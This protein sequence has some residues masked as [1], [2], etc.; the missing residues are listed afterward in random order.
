MKNIRFCFLIFIG[1][2]TIKVQAQ[3]A[4]N[5][6]DIFQ[7][8]LIKIAKTINKEQQSD[9]KKFAENGKFVKTL[10]DALKEP[11]SFNYAFDSLKT[12]S[13]IKSPDQVFRII[14][15]YL[16]LENGTYR[17]YGAIQMNNK[18]ALKLLPL[19]DQTDNLSDPN[20]ITNNQKWFGA[21]YY[22][23]IPVTTSGRLPYYILLGW[24]GNT[25][26][27]TKKVI[28]ILSFDK[29][30]AT[31]GMPV[32]DGKELKGKNRIIFEY[33]KQNAMFLKTDK[34]AGLIVFD[35]LAPFDPE[36]VGKF[37]FYGSDGNTDAFKIVGGRL[38]LQE[39]VVLKNEAN[40][41]DD[42]YIDPAKNVK[43]VKK[44]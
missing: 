31:F 20:A 27:T 42:L 10:V 29:D 8:S 35:H 15:W 34:H 3:Q 6:L 40:S 11:N 23:I 18:G 4:A 13:V 7:D 25:V 36:M 17:Y 26:E 39:N 14:S 1:F 28:E 37:Q 21:R 2:S 16:Q 43:P 24:K 19:I 33:Q 38:K 32:F 41:N 12:I 9:E 22:E 5:K 44:F 30:M